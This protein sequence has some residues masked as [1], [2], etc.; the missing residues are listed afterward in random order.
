[1]IATQFFTNFEGSSLLKTYIKKQITL[2]FAEIIIT[3]HFM[4]ES[5]LEPVPEFKLYN[6]AAVRGATFFGG[7]LVAGFLIAENFRSLGHYNKV[8][9]TWLCTIA[10]TILLFGGAFLVPA[11]TN[12]PNY[13]IPFIYAWIAWFIVQRQQGAEIKKHLKAG[14][15]LFSF[16]RVAAISLVGLV[17][18][19]GTLY[20]LVVLTDKQLFF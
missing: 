3:P 8:R 18:T 20:L 7:P 10:F 2:I 14:G 5:I 19:F 17:I 13:I 4:E 15:G 12:I 9:T 1:M 11:V 16:W 6:E